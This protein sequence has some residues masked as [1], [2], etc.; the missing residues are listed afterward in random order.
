MFNYLNKERRDV[1]YLG[2]HLVVS[3]GISVDKTLFNV[4][5][6]DWKIRYKGDVIL[7]FSL[8]YTQ[9]H[10]DENNNTKQYILKSAADDNIT[11]TTEKFHQFSRDDR[12]YML[13]NFFYEFTC[14]AMIM[15][16]IHD[17]VLRTLDLPSVD[18]FKL[19]MDDLIDKY[20]RDTIIIDERL[21]E[22]FQYLY[23]ARMQ[24]IPI[25]EKNEINNTDQLKVDEK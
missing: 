7:R 3:S 11:F 8:M 20:S 12:V 2:Q 15:R 16:K 19:E 18:Y 5:Y 6:D 13:K 4:K 9:G 22:V 24:K 10:T 17:Y 23:D 21:K 14:F 1:L 25:L